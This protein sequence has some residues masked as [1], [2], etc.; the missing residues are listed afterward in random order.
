MGATL[1][2]FIAIRGER[3]SHEADV[4]V[5]VFYEFFEDAHHF[6]VVG[7]LRCDGI[8]LNTGRVGLGRLRGFRLPVFLPANEERDGA[9]QTN[10]VDGFDEMFVA[11]GFPA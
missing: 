8:D 5:Q 9:D 7:V 4:L 10:P 2:L 1:Q 6:R 11:S 3:L